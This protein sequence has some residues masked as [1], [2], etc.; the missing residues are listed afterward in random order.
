MTN[1]DPLV[2]RLSEALVAAQHRYRT[3]RGWGALVFPAISSEQLDAFAAALAPIFRIAA[4][5][6]AAQ[7]IHREAS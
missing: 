3:Q 5:E 2:A 4:A 7:L 6:A 1:P